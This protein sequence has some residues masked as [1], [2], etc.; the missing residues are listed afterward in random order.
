MNTIL[1]YHDYSYYPYE[2]V[3]AAREAEMLLGG[4]ALQE[5][6]KTLE[7][8]GGDLKNAERLTYFAQFRQ[9]D[10]T[11]D[12]LQARLERAVSAQKRQAT[13]YSVHGLH[14]YKGKFNPQIAKA[15]MNISGVHEGSRVLDPFC[16]SGTTLVEAA[17]LGARAYGYDI[18]PFAVFLANAKLLSLHAPAASLSSMLQAIC[19]VAKE[20]GAPKA[21]PDARTVY[22][23]NWFDPDILETIERLRGGIVAH[24]GK[25]A[26]IFLVLASN[27]LRDYS[28]Q[29]PKDLRIRRRKSP[30]PLTPFLAAFE[31][32]SRK[33]IERLAASQSILGLSVG[34]G[35]AILQD[36]TQK[37]EAGLYDAAITSP[38]YAM[39]LPYI[40]TQRLSLVWLGLEDP[41]NIA[42]LESTLVGSREWRGAKQ[43][44]LTQLQTN[45]ARLPESE[46][47]LCQSAL[48]ALSP[49]DGFR[50]KAVP[51]LLYRY[52][53][54]MRS[55]FVTVFEDV[56]PGGLYMLVVGHN[57]TVLGGNRLD[58]DTPSHLASLAQ[59][60][61][62]QVEELIPLQTYQRWGYHAGNAVAAETLII[63]RRP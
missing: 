18:N 8:V 46:Y 38:P 16:G 36:V 5:R 13:R 4:E 50:R 57:H 12:T 11:T 41:S 33:F 28:L 44:I 23:G 10:R 2:K 63:L 61:G 51:G 31:L 40:D 1:A 58:I 15:L 27:L 39:A 9:G 20:P 59:S 3:L 56:K 52:F 30:L 62:W 19:R 35:L 43:E 53:T 55:S 48:Q 7:I 60:V 25:F 34:Q 17:Q 14:E 47:T 29:D 54:A 49:S 6:G 45:E 26:P 21:E 42:R 32:E 37:R 22:L 24:S